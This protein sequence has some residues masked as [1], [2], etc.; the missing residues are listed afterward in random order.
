MRPVFIFSG[1]RQPVDAVPELTM[2]GA[3]AIQ[4]LF[5]VLE[6]ALKHHLSR[7][8]LWRRKWGW[9]VKPAAGGTVGALGEEGR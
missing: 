3:F 2:Q 6:Q 5:L 9:G 8:K 7:E 4:A 1:A